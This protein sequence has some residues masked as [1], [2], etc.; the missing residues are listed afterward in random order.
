VQFLYVLEKYLYK[1]ANTIVTALPYVN[2][3]L[4][5]RGIQKKDNVFWIPN[6]ADL[7]ETS[8]ISDE[9]SMKDGSN[10]ILQSL[11]DNTKREI[12]NV[13]YVG[14]LGPANR[15]DSILAA[16]KLL[17]EQGEDKIFF[18]I[19]GSGHSKQSLENY[20]AENNITNAKIWPSVS[21]SSVS[22]ILKQSDVGVLCLHDNP[23]YKYGVNLHKIYDYAS[24][25][26]PIV[27]AANV[28]NN[29][30]DLAD[31]FN[32][33]AAQLQGKISNINLQIEEV[34]VLCEKH[35][36]PPEVFE[37]IESL[38]KSVNKDFTS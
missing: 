34:S 21:G 17:K 13:V 10:L 15:V 24:A 12:M 32:S 25:G 7:S 4:V 36:V 6:A 2:E 18:T 11:K 23:I 38:H 16:A 29:L 35:D 28:R 22:S 27:F 30:V 20:V 37:K 3:Y 31:C 14:G 33:M 9:D 5:Q 1:R 8:D 26:L 19:V